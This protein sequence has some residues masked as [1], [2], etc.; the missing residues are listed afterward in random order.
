MLKKSMRDGCKLRTNQGT[1]E[2][3]KISYNFIFNSNNHVPNHSVE[4]NY[5]TPG[6]GINEIHYRKHKPEVDL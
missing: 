5:F 1:S 3:K 2:L 6:R 4:K